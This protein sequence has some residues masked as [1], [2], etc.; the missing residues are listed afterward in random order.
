MLAVLRVSFVICFKLNAFL[1]MQDGETPLH[2][3]CRFGHLRVVK[4]LLQYIQKEKGG[5]D[6]GLY[7]NTATNKGESALHY[8]SKLS[9]SNTSVKNVHDAAREIAQLLLD[10]GASVY[11]QTKDV[12]TIAF[13]VLSGARQ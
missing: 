6:V 3:A 12:R 10:G 1:S 4:E 13:C 2:L 7:I 11:Q 9:E 8:A 5:T